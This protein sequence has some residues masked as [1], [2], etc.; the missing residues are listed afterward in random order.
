MR[1]DNLL[2]MM[3]GL[4]DGNNQLAAALT[5]NAC[6]T[7]AL[8][9]TGTAPTSINE[10][11]GTGSWTP[12]GGALLGAHRYWQGLQATDGTTMWPAATGALGGFDPIRNDPT[13]TAFLPSGCNPSPTCTVNCC[14]S[15]C[16]PYITILLTDGEET[17]G[18]DA[19]VAA[20][21]LLN[22]TVIDGR[23][24]RIETKPIGFGIAAGDA[25]IE[26]IAINGSLTGNLPGN[27]GFYANDEA[28]L[29]LAISQILDDAIRTEVCNGVDDD[30]D[31]TADEGFTTGTACSNNRLGVCRVVGTTGCR[32][33]GAGTQCSAGREPECASAVN[34]T[35]CSVANAA[36]TQVAGT[37]QTGV[38]NPTAAGTPGG[39]SNEVAVRLQRPRRRLRWQ[40]RR[41]RHRLRVRPDHRG[42]RRHRQ[43]L[44]RQHR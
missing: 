12:L 26:E 25:D 22:S 27:D 15:Q 20:T 9:A 17:C 23:R 29:Q 11:W 30:C 32:A 1:S 18:G 31:N 38:C 21:T 19:D 16:R 35:A 40:G 41:E 44:R 8:P 24:Y 13:T 37:C 14:A 5:D 33:D 34:G 10:I 28:G 43:R 4:V 7:C 39:A 36:N 42:V 6:G 2:Q 3:T